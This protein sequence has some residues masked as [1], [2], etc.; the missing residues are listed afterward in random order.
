MAEVE[1][2]GV[3]ALVNFTFLF[4]PGDVEISD[5]E[6]SSVTGDE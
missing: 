3:K 5:F 1:I 2:S 4:K 6:I